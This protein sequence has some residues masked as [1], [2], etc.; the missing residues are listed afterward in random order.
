LANLTNVNVGNNP[1]DAT[2][3]ETFNRLAA[4]PAL[5]HLEISNSK[6]VSCELL[7]QWNTQQHSTY[8][9]VRTSQPEHKFSCVD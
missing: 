1:I 9:T 2:N 7:D 4:L 3:S 8:R 5:L 6:S